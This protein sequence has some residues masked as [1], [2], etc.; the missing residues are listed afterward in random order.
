MPAASH[1]FDLP[2][3]KLVNLPS[4]P[5]KGGANPEGGLAVEALGSTRY[6]GRDSAIGVSKD[7]ANLGGDESDSDSDSQESTANSSPESATEDCLTCLDT[8]EAAV[9]ST[10]KKF[11]KKVWASCSLTK[12]GLWK[13]VKLGWIGDSH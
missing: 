7:N 10:C 13:E 6:H 12:W 11:C 8:K 1:S 3:T 5:V 4:S 9:K 2:E